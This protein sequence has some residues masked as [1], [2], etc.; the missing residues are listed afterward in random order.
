[1]KIIIISFL[2]SF[3]AL[4]QDKYVLPED[5]IIARDKLIASKKK[6]D[7][8]I[9]VRY[10]QLCQQKRINDAEHI[11]MLAYREITGDDCLSLIFRTDI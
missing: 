8:D 4:A 5:I 2:I 9:L 11:E 10:Y 7:R 1:M 6:L 3:S